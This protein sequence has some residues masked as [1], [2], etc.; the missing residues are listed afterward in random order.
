MPVLRNI[1][2]QGEAHATVHGGQDIATNPSISCCSFIDGSFTQQ[3]VHVKHSYLTYL[4]EYPSPRVKTVSDYIYPVSRSVHGLQQNNFDPVPHGIASDSVIP[5]YD[6]SGR[7]VDF[8]KC[9]KRE[10]PKLNICGDHTEQIRSHIDIDSKTINQNNN[11]IMSYFTRNTAN[12]DQIVDT[13]IIDQAKVNKIESLKSMCMS[14][15]SKRVKFTLSQN[16]KDE[17]GQTVLST[18]QI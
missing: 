9:L 2:P 10:G 3:S 7:N 13:P 5:L 17:L 14:L 8:I 12:T 1:L 11:N 18:C 15:I 16:L 4:Y 6:I